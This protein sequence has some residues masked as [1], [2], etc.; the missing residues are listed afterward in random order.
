MSLSSSEPRAARAF[1]RLRAARKSVAPVVARACAVV[2]PM[3]EEV[4]VI[5]MVLPLRAL[6]MSLSWMIW[7]AVGRASPG[8]L[9]SL[10]TSAYRVERRAILKL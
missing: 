3:P 8:P 9:G 1:G 10:W 7:R 4:P 5:K 6:V 2:M